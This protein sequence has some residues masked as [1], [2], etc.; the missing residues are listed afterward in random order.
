MTV[1]G[2]DCSTLAVDLSYLDDDTDQATWTRIPLPRRKTTRDGDRKRR[3]SA[4]DSTAAIRVIRAEFPRR[5]AL[6]TL[7]VRLVVV[8]DPVGQH[9]HTAKWL[10]EITG[11]VKALIPPEL[12]LLSLTPG[13]WK[14]AN[15]LPYGCKKQI[16]TAHARRQLELVQNVD[17]WPP[18]AFDAY[19]CALAGRTIHDHAREAA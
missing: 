6:E 13:D 5:H 7:G 12:P 19:L 10:G 16:A 17:G 1:V 9:A 14:T 2:V 4:A 18:D 15:G 11:A 8:E 3:D